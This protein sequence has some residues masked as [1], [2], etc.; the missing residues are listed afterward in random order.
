[1]SRSESIGE[2]IINTI[3]DG[4]LFSAM[5]PDSPESTC[6]LTWSANAKEQLTQLI[7][8]RTASNF[9]ME[10]LGFIADEDLHDMLWWRTDG[11]YAPVTFWI[12]CNDLFAWGFADAEDLTP[13][14]LPVLKQAVADCKEIDSVCGSITGCELFACRMRKMRPQGA[15]YPEERELWPLFDVC[16][17]E[18]ETGLGNP[19]KPGEY[20]KGAK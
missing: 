16:G 10:V 9:V 13:E 8:Q 7:Q 4:K 17:P 14:S 15:A 5:C 2:E 11:E 6:L 12:N 18:R 3:I 1:M 20:K 19:Y